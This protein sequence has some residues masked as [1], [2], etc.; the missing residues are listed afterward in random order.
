MRACVLRAS[1]VPAH[2]L[3]C[4]TARMGNVKRPTE[5]ERGRKGLAN[6]RK[7]RIEMEK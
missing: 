1:Y 5:K 6:D 3:A 7:Y 4:K 2:L